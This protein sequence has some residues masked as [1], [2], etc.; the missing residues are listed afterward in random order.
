[1]AVDTTK[2]RA[3]VPAVGGKPKQ[4]PLVF[5]TTKTVQAQDQPGPEVCPLCTKHAAE[6]VTRQV[7]TLYRETATG[8]VPV[9]ATPA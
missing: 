5:N 2:C 9:R 8:P 4:C 6:L 7:I 1:M 3:G